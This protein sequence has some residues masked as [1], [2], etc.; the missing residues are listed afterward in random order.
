MGTIITAPG[1][2]P[3]P[4]HAAHAGRITLAHADTA[5]DERIGG[6]KGATTWWLDG[7]TSYV[8]HF[9]SG[10]VHGWTVADETDTAIAALD[11]L[12][13]GEDM[14]PERLW[15]AL[16]D[17]RRLRSRLEAL[18][19]EL[20]LYAREAGPQGR[21]RMALREIGEA[22]GL[23]HTTVAERCERARDGE[24]TGWRHWLVQGTA[25]ADLYPGD[26]GPDSPDLYTRP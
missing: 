20:T 2:T 6:T 23:H 4:Q 15:A 9:R 26:R 8:V 5:P 3:A 14:S 22:T 7:T 21:P 25:R 19:V 17:V 12:R 10:Q 13:E 24:H 1:S 18:E 11:S 16:R